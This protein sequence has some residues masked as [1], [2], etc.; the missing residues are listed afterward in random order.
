MFSL[1]PLG[2]EIRSG[3]KS[4]VLGKTCMERYVFVAFKSFYIKHALSHV[5]FSRSRV[6]SFSSAFIRFSASRSSLSMFK[7]FCLRS[8]NFSVMASPA[9]CSS[10]YAFP[11]WTVSL[12]TSHVTVLFD[13]FVF[14]VAC[15]GNRTAGASLF[16][17]DSGHH[18]NLEATTLSFTYTL[19]FSVFFKSLDRKCRQHTFV[20]SVKRKSFPTSLLMACNHSL[21]LVL[22]VGKLKYDIFSFF[23][24]LYPFWLHSGTQQKEGIIEH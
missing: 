23:S 5:N 1:Q 6:F 4:I 14:L 20:F 10:L 3:Y 22:S 16:R 24:S 12:H 7:C 17:G 15:K 8:S 2:L 19:P 18:L 21:R 11:F 9:F 13:C